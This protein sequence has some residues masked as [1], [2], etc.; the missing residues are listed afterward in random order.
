MRRF[1]S[2]FKRRPRRNTIQQR[3]VNFQKPKRVKRRVSSVPKLRRDWLRIFAK[4]RIPLIILA[5]FLILFTIH[6]SPTFRIQIVDV[7]RENLSVDI[8]EIETFLAQQAFGKHYFKTS[9]SDLYEQLQQEFPQWENVVLSK[10]FPNTV[11]AKVQNLKP[12]A[13]V[14][15]QSEQNK[16]IFDEEGNPQETD[17]KTIKE[18]KYVINLQGNISYP[19]DNE[20]API[21]I[22]YQDLFEGDI[23]IGTSIISSDY[24][25][26]IQ[27]VT[28]ALL[29]NFDL[30]TKEVLFFQAAKEV[31]INVF[32]YSL[33]IDLEQDIDLQ[34]QKYTQAISAINTGGV[35]Y[36]DLRIKNRVIYKGRD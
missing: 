14:V 27:K 21:T 23:V 33:W 26:K 16:V 4:I 32:Q 35:E 6:T 15:L 25:Q 30:A 36:F 19:D 34:I 22:K 5:I 8:T 17:E 11:I 3:V 2:F 13:Y 24:I 28:D 1:F 18:E 29:D 20:K 31:H 7:Q 9:I 12:F 10:K